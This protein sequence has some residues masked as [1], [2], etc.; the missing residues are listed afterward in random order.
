MGT[1]STMAAII[2]TLGLVLPGGSSI[3]A[4]D[5]NHARLAAASGSGSL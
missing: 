4:V 5:A 2:E 1:A 3:P